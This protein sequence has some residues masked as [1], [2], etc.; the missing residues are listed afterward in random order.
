M[1]KYSD[2]L[3]VKIPWL[4][5]YEKFS[6]ENV[7]SQFLKNCPTITIK[8]FSFSLYNTHQYQGHHRGLLLWEV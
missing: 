6:K 7:Y 1:P 4:A 2:N 3:Y 5:S 8:Q